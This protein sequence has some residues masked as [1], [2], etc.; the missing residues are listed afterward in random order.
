MP[1]I[2]LSYR[3]DDSKWIAGRIFD[4]LEGHYGRG[5][6]FMDIDTIPVGLDF[7]EY[8]QQSL[9]RCDIL[10]AVVG[11]RWLGTDEHGRHAVADE[12]DWVRI[13][14]ETAL[15]KKIPVIPIL[16][17]RLRMPK[18]SD[19][20]ETL[21]DFAFRQAAEVDS[22]V[23][24]RSH[25]ERLIRSMDQ[26][27]QRRS[28]E[29]A[30]SLPAK[31]SSADAKSSDE[32]PSTRSLTTR[33]EGAPI[34][35]PLAP[36]IVISA[37]LGLLAWLNSRTGKP[38]IRLAMLGV[39]VLCIAGVPILSHAVPEQYAVAA[40][41]SSILICGFGLAL[42]AAAVISHPIEAKNR[43]TYIA[44]CLGLGLILLV[45]AWI[46][47]ELTAPNL[48]ITDWRIRSVVIFTCVFVGSAVILSTVV[49]WLATKGAS[50]SIA[51]P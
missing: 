37:P 46:D 10:L 27:L 12:T 20:P 48:W 32:S 41:W 25:M 15:A 31:D 51:R 7:R 50:K 33:E 30:T 11:P 1:T 28:A 2:V 42:V 49:F 26:Y 23:D 43:N 16:I 24:F 21:R 3:R 14:I 36:T 5:N 38:G 6:V 34:P 17:D 44:I 35:A 4:R 45:L 39:G 29:P 40:A 47:S 18:A 9:E 22:G 13:E 19:L 8:L